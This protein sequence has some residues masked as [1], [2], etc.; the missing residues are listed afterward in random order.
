MKNEHLL[1]LLDYY[2]NQFEN[3]LKKLVITKPNDTILSL[4]D[5]FNIDEKTVFWGDRD[6]GNIEN[7]LKEIS[8]ANQEAFL[9][10]LFSITLIDH[11]LFKE[12]EGSKSIFY[13]DFRNVTAY[14]KFGWLGSS[15]NFE[16]PKKIVTIPEQLAIE[17]FHQ[18]KQY[19]QNFAT[20]FERICTNILQPVRF[21]IFVTNTN[22]FITN[23]IKN[24]HL[25]LEEEDKGTIFEMLYLTI[26][27]I[28]QH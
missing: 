27:S 4:A 19:P 21:T 8:Q 6:W 1:H 17:N 13:T 7:D 28:V 14:P 9:L 20:L 18:I 10:C 3:D 12:L 23:L 5:F 11:T 16:N 24:E 26:G 15:P 2:N 25:F 22:H